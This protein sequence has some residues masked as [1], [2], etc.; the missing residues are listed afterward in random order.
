MKVNW[1][2]V[3]KPN[4]TVVRTRVRQL[5]GMPQRLVVLTMK[6]LTNGLARRQ[7]QRLQLTDDV[8]EL[9]E[10]EYVWAAMRPKVTTDNKRI[11]VRFG[12]PEDSFDQLVVRKIGG[13]LHIEIELQ[14]EQ[15][16]QP[17]DPTERFVSRRESSTPKVLRRA[18]PLPHVTE[19]PAWHITEDHQ[20]QIELQRSVTSKGSSGSAND[21]AKPSGPRRALKPKRLKKTNDA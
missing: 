1:L 10:S 6:P 14:H 5:F 8:F 15:P 19:E 11:V 13:I 16:V 9:A 20:L 21:A 18:I 12:L 7:R 2:H 3:L 17:E 4:W